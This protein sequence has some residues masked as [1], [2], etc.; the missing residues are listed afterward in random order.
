[1]GMALDHG[2]LASRSDVSGERATKTGN[3]I[4]VGSVIVAAAGLL[5]L[6]PQDVWRKQNLQ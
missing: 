6:V 3:L 1:M 2:W 5:L 4:L